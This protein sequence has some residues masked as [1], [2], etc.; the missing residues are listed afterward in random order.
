MITKMLS[1]ESLDRTLRHLH[2]VSQSPSLSLML[3]SLG[4][5]GKLADDLGVVDSFK[6]VNGHS[7]FVYPSPFW[8]VV[9]QK[10]WF[11][12]RFKRFTPSR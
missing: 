8:K 12:G 2:V 1:F 9:H 10:C 3:K 5:N 11:T 6:A 7:I 4:V